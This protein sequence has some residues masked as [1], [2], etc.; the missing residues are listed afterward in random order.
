[1]LSPAEKAELLKDHEFG[2]WRLRQR[3]PTAIGVT[4]L[5]R[6]GYSDDHR[7]AAVY[8]AL[9]PGTLGGYGE[10]YVL[11]WT[12]GAWQVVTVVPAWVS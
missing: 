3:Y 10:Y 5:S 1:M 9:H 6:V 8:V 2:L 11:E 7:T 12:D 4:T